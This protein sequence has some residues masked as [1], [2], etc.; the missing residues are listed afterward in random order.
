MTVRAIR[1]RP[2]YEEKL[3]NKQYFV[4]QGKLDEALQRQSKAA[5]ETDTLEKTVDKDIN[6]KTEE[7]KAL[8]YD[9]IRHY[10]AASGI[11]QMLAAARA[12]NPDNRQLAEVAA[13]FAGIEFEPLPLPELGAPAYFPS[14]R[15]LLAGVAALV[16]FPEGQARDEVGQF[17]DEQGLVL[18]P[19][20]VAALECV[21]EQAADQ[22]AKQRQ[23][24]QQPAALARTPWAMCSQP[25]GVLTGAGPW[26]FLPSLIVWYTRGSNTVSLS[27]TAIMARPAR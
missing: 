13:E 5:Q 7:G 3:Q 26:P 2:Q 20:K 12:D 27:I 16:P 19:V 22:G 4:V 15:S 10:A 24:Y 14:R 18:A 21:A 9:L 6:L 8:V 11:Q 23:Q 17:A 1:F 25:A